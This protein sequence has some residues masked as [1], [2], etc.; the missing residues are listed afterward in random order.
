VAE[1]FA[2]ALVRL[3]ERGADVA[4]PARF[5]ALAAM[6]RRAHGHEGAAREVIDARIAVLLGAFEAPA[7]PRDAAPCTPAGAELAALTA[8][9]AAHAQARGEAP[10][11]APPGA[12][13]AARPEPRVLDHVRHVW[14]RLSA[15][16]RFT[17]SLE[18]LPD[19]PGP[20]NSQHLV[21]RAL[22]LMREV[23]PGYL[24]RFMARVDAL[25]ALEQW[26]AAAA[27]TAMPAP[28][29]RAEGGARKANRTRKAR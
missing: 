7:E 21:H 11:P 13:L 6:V 26:Q 19:N 28:G 9:L 22:M 4:Q 8:R 12:G 15:E 18:A 3:R 2:A 23:S 24:H 20:L 10:L 17:Q 25:A 16:R 27:A 14:A 5:H 29:A 1:D